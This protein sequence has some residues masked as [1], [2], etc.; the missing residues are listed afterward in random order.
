[1]WGLRDPEDRALFM[2][3]LQTLLVVEGAIIELI[4]SVFILQLLTDLRNT[5]MKRQNQAIILERRK[6]V[7][8]DSETS[9]SV[10]QIDSPKYKLI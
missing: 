5:S 10:L 2:M 6:D 1:M 9:L 8:T 4:F 7:A 3:P